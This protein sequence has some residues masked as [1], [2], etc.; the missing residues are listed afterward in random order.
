MP[1]QIT[2]KGRPSIHGERKK[3]YSVSVTQEGWNKLKEM[4]KES[5]LSLSE[6]L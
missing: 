5:E 4:A 3:S 2:K 6:F 1:E